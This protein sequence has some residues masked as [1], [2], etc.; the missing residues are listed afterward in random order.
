M[1]CRNS[2]GVEVDLDLQILIFKLQSEGLKICMPIAVA[3]VG[4][5]LVCLLHQFL[6]FREGVD[7]D[8]VLRSD[9]A[10]NN[11]LSNLV[12]IMHAFTSSATRHCKIYYA[13]H[14]PCHHHQQDP[15]DLHILVWPYYDDTVQ[16]LNM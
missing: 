4:V 5:K 11:K 6:S 13:D 12:A 9:K 16:D 10:S 2:G 14:Q 1:L 8:L 3:E 7:R 15:T